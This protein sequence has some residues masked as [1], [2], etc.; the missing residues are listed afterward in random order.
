MTEVDLQHIRSW[1][2]VPTTSVSDEQLQ[3]VVDAESRSQARICRVPAEPA[4]YP[5]DLEQALYRRVARHLAA[6]SIPTGLV[7][8]GEYG[9]SRLPYFDAEIERLEGPVRMVVFG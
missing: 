6:K 5:Q 9:P 7:G 3:Q 8:V 2:G 4:P 1:V